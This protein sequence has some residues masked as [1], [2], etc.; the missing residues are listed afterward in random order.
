LFVLG[1]LAIGSRMLGG[2]R[3]R[4]PARALYLGCFLPDMI[5]KPLFYG[6]LLARGRAGELISGTR[7]FGH[8]GLFLLAV[9]AAAA[10]W[11]SRALWAIA[12]G[13]ATH[14]F[15]DNLGDYIG[16]GPPPLERSSLLALLFPALG[17]RFP[18]VRFD[19][20]VDHLLANAHSAY[21]I[22]GELI[23]GAILLRA[24]RL[25]RRVQ[26]S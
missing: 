22:A 15:L 3:A 16:F 12:A 5:D 10:L 20:L 23:G 1:H 24:W 21:V 13:I 18:V 7:T 6:V 26:S 2:L 11:R 8:T 19:S 17:V 14:L 4:L 25:R 9:C